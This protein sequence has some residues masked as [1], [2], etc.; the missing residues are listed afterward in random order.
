M[1]TILYEVLKSKPW[2]PLVYLQAQFEIISIL[3]REIISPY[4][5]Y[6]MKL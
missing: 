1:P 3:L 4:K 6:E 5:S 2:F